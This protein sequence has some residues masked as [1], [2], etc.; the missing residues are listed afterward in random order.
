MKLFHLQRIILHN[1]ILTLYTTF[2]YILRDL[3]I[4]HYCNIHDLSTNHISIKQE[5]TYVN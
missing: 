5:Y 4:I 2:E 3:Q 1:T